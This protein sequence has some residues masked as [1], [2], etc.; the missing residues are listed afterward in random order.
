MEEDL[1]RLHIES[2]HILRCDQGH[3]HVV[4]SATKPDGEEVEFER[5]VD[6]P[7]EGLRHLFEINYI[8]EH[9]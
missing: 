5:E 9:L 4:V 7:E 2:Y 1:A 6:T 3:W 8:E